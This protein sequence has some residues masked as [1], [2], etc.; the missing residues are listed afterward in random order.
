MIGVENWLRSSGPQQARREAGLRPTLGPRGSNL[1]RTTKGDPR[2]G[3]KAGLGGSS[4]VATRVSAG[5]KRT[6]Q[7][8]GVD[9]E[10]A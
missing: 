6:D 3:W 2:I 1:D 8:S 4:E 9:S 5:H 10:E 7:S